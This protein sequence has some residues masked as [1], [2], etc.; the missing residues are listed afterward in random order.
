MVK[1][2]LCIVVGVAA[3]FFVWNVREANR[4]LDE[5]AGR[6]AEDCRSSG[7]RAEER[8][9]T[10]RG[11]GDMSMQIFGPT[12]IIICHQPIKTGT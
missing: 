12:K 9:L 4:R 8:F 10:P 5:E 1:V 6:S 3:I 11:S 2:I 7:G